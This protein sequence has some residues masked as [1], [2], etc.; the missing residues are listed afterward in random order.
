MQAYTKLLVTDLKSLLRYDPETGKFYWLKDT[1]SKGK[2]GHEAGSTNE[3]GYVVI[4]VHGRRI[5]AHVVAWLFEKGE[6]PLNLDHIN[7]NRTDNRIVNLRSV[8]TQEN[9]WNTIK[10][11]YNTSGTLGVCW[12]KLEQKWKAYIMHNGK[13]LHLGYFCSLEAAVAARKAKEV[14]LGRIPP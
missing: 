6:Y 8:T 4:G 9:T 7:G 1:R 3:R 12:N 2:A 13:N 11:K 10:H 5:Y 14:E